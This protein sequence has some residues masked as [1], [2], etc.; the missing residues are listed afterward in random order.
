M[1]ELEESSLRLLVPEESDDVIEHLQ[2]VLVEVY[3]STSQDIGLLP[4]IA[5]VSSKVHV[6]T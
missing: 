1:D 6:G 5:L 2:V 3:D 4:L